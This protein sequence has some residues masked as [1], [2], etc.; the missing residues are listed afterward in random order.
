MAISCT[1]DGIIT[2]GEHRIIRD[3][4]QES[5]NEEAGKHYMGLFREYADIALSGN[6][7][8]ANICNR[9]NVELNQRQKIIVMMHLLE[10]AHVDGAMDKK[11]LEFVD[12]VA[13]SFK[14]DIHEYNLL[15]AFI[16]DED[17][18]TLGLSNI[19]VIS[20]ERL[21]D[22]IKHIVR[23]NINA[24][25][26]VL[27]IPS[28]EMYMLRYY[29][30]SGSLTLNGFRL[31]EKHT[32]NFPTG[33]VIKSDLSNPVYYSDIVGYFFQDHNQT[34]ICFEAKHVYY[35]FTGGKIGL[36]DINIV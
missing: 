31:R 18:L 22:K 8:P 7:E 35:S 11:E 34:K 30:G 2:E 17:A 10:L 36:R 33:S 29:G 25:L 16:T 21:P 12:V 20:Q 6:I 27:R 4:I 23:P 26:A 9:I 15:K 24:K 5:L 14:I 19:L 32:Y 3:F 28:V 1:F 13:E